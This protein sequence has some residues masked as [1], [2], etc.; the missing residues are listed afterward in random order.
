MHF[1]L[2]QL[3]HLTTSRGRIVRP[4]IHELTALV[5]EVTSPVGGLSLITNGMGERR[6]AD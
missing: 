1:L 2:R 5:E 6:L 3:D 4:S